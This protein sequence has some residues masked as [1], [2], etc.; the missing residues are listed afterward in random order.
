MRQL[1]RT[2]RRIARNRH[3][4]INHRLESSPLND[5]PRRVSGNQLAHFRTHF[6]EAVQKDGVICLE[7]GLTFK[8]LPQHLGKHQLSSH[9]YRAKWGYNRTTP[10]ERLST[11]S[12]KRRNA[13]AMKLWRLTPRDAHQKAI[14]ARTGHGLPFRPEMRL[15][16][17]EA[18]RARVAAGFRRVGKFQTRPKRRRQFELN[19]DFQPSKDDRR[20]LSLRNK[21]LWPSEIAPLMGIRAEWVHHRLGRLKKKGITFQPPT[22][23]WPNANRKVTDDEVLALAKSG[24]SVPEIAVKVGVRISSVHRRI[25]R[26]QERG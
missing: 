1:T 11:R 19:S 23:P 7:C 8:S 24:L 12:K 26:L 21:G 10:L 5:I 18:A 25:K 20:I 6:R 15:V 4:P 13:F 3:L 9:E 2:R 16:D 14:R 22:R 17:T